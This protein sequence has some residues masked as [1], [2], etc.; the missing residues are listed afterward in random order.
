MGPYFRTLT[1][2]FT[3]FCFMDPYFRT[4]TEIFTTFCFMGPYF[5]TLTEISICFKGPYFRTL[6][7]IT[8]FRST[9]FFFFWEG[10]TFMTFCFMGQYFRTLT[11]ITVFGIHILKDLTILRDFYIFVLWVPILEPI[12]TYIVLYSH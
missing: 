4:L 5:R 2:I 10:G 6:T 8:L 11:E 3:T 1:E 12:H 9:F 7:E